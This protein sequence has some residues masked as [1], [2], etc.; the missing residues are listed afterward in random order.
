MPIYGASNLK[1]VLGEAVVRIVVE[2]DAVVDAAVH[3]V[4][5]VVLPAGVAVA[6]VVVQAQMNTNHASVLFVEFPSTWLKTA[7][8]LTLQLL[9]A[10]RSVVNTSGHATRT[11]TYDVLRGSSQTMSWRSLNLNWGD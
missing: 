4:V 1:E 10:S 11:E 5:H 8:R 3:E 9:P 7:P 6:S 2:V